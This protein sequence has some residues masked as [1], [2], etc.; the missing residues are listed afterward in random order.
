LDNSQANVRGLRQLSLTAQAQENN[1]RKELK[2]SSIGQ[3]VSTL[4]ISESL[5]GTATLELSLLPLHEQIYRFG[6]SAIAAGCQ[7]LEILPLF[8]L[9]G[10]HVIEDIPAAVAI[11]QTALGRD[12]QIKLQPHIGDRTCLQ[13][14]FLDRMATLG[15]EK[16]I[17]L[18]H[19]SRRPG[20]N[21]SVIDLA[22]R[23]GAEVAYW[24]MSPTLAERVTSL[25]EIGYRRIAIQPYFLF[26][27]GITDAIAQQVKNLQQQ[28]PHVEL[29]LGEP[30]EWPSLLEAIA[31][32]YG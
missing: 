19:G 14:L 18:S 17:L 6:R 16:Q 12:L 29:I 25:V 22:A 1:S 28:F 24:S 3:F 4:G 30:I 10:V 31:I 5:V 2:S 9:P 21:R 26:A 8:L 13:K 32:S 7:Q 23:G 11:A 15:G 27:G 20:G